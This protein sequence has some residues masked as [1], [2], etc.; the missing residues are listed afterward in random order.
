M[1]ASFDEGAIM[2]LPTVIEPISVLGLLTQIA[3]VLIIGVALKEIS[4]RTGFPFIVALI[5]AGTAAASIG[6]L[7]ITAWSGFGEL[8]RTLALIIIVFSAGFRLQ[9]REI[10]KDSKVIMMLATLGVLITFA[11]ITGLMFSL[12]SISL[13]TA[14]FLG[15]LLS[16]SDSASITESGNVKGRLTTILLSE[17]VFNQPLTLILPLLLLDYI[18]KPELA[19][20]NIPKFF[21]LVGV[22]AAVGFVGAVLGQKILLS[23][24]TDHEEIAGLMIAV[25]VFVIAENL[26]GSGILAVAITALLLSSRHIPA[27]EVLGTF[28]QQLAFLFTVFVFVLLGM[29]FSFQQLAQLSITRSEIIAV[30]ITLVVARLAS[31]MIVLFKT[32]LGL[33]ERLKIGLIAPKGIAPAALAPL[34]LVT[35]F[36]GAI[37]V[38]KI[39][40]IAIIISVFLSLIF[41]KL[42]GDGQGIKEQAE[43]KTKEH[44]LKKAVAQ[45]P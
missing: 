10:K 22:G 42:G 36:P 25:S 12:L 1:N 17:S 19:L 35:G 38:V 21:L 27:K 16:G 43:A 7:E 28:S 6:L 23:L 45:E 29:Q 31:S 44:I 39:V 8:I 18:V 40:Y 3:T 11:L 5:L 30:V 32:G 26:F 2:V 24:K 20:L 41:F 14:A 4:N 33:K 37:Q 13:I 15:A 34:L 9:L